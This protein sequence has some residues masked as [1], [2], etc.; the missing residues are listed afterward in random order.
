MFWYI[1]I[2]ILML[3][4]FGMVIVGNVSGKNTKHMA[5]ISACFVLCFFM[6]MRGRNVGV[7]T[8]Y[9]CYV[10]TQFPAIPW[11][12]ILTAE[13]YAT[14]A[15]IWVFDFEPGYRIYNKLLSCLSDAEQ[16]I[17]IG[18][19]IFIFILLYRLI[20]EK[21]PDYLLSI[22]LYITL[23]IY[24]TEMNVAR[25]AIAILIVYNS[26]Q[27]IEEKK[28]WKYLICCLVAA[29]FHMAALTFI[30]VYWIVHRKKIT[31]LQFV[32]LVGVSVVL[33][34][35]FPIISPYITG[36]LPYSL[37][38]YFIKENMNLQSLMVGMFNV[39]VFFI[40]YLMVQK[41]ER[42]N[43]LATN[44]IGLTMILLNTCC[45]GL[46]IG[47]GYASRLAALFGP[48]LIIFIPQI[49]ERIES[50]NKKSLAK[51]CIVILCGLVYVGRLLINNI[52]GTMPYQFFWQ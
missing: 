26:F 13:T 34:I 48:Y 16:M 43:I 3:Y 42:K 38:K 25:N 37:G 51:A 29:S 47:L 4:P 12:K 52:G 19:S 1:V 44:K 2:C 40:S 21:S 20:R 6:A 18:N 36:M 50:Q 45:F 10:F 7:D 32:V 8:K 5:L 17:T 15:A 30:P 27:F 41:K 35:V 22:W 28:I 24:Q 49:L 14:E 23:G 11:N 46:N 33:G 31:I 39:G 9:Y